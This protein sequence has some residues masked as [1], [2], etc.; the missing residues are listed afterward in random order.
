MSGETGEEDAFALL[1][2]KL[3]ASQHN[4]NAQT[5]RAGHSEDAC[6]YPEANLHI[7]IQQKLIFPE[8]KQ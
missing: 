2:E 6:M 3:F 4:Y 1:L 5:E 8:D 7:P